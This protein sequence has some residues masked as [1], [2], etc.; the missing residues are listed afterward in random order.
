[1]NLNWFDGFTISYRSLLNGHGTGIS[2]TKCPSPPPFLVYCVHGFKT[3]ICIRG[4]L[5]CKLPSDWRQQRF[6]KQFFW[7]TLPIFNTAEG[8][9]KSETVLENSRVQQLLLATSH[10]PFRYWKYG[11]TLSTVVVA[12]KTMF[13]SIS[14]Q[15]T[16]SLWDTQDT[17]VILWSSFVPFTPNQ[18]QRKMALHLF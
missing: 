2:S 10:F 17:S 4:G 11:A 1:M 8:N 16:A 5:K 15:F 13:S 9:S 3:K 14:S 7:P 6:F 18:T 12:S